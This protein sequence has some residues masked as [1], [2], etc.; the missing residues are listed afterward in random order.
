MVNYEKKLDYKDLLFAST[1]HIMGAGIFFLIQY[2]YESSKEKTWMSIVLSGLFMLIFSTAYSK[3]PKI[4][5]ENDNIEQK[6]ITNKFNKNIANIIILLTVI[7]MIFG[8]YIVSKSFGE[9]FSNL[10]NVS[11][12]IS[13]LLII[14]LC[15]LLNM[16]KIDALANFNNL[17]VLIGTGFTII[18]ILIG[19]YQIII[20]KNNIDFKSYYT[21]TDFND[22]KKNIWNIIKGAYLIIFAYFGFEII[23]KLNKESINPKKDI[24]NAINHS[25]YF[26]I[27]IYGLMGFIYAYSMSL[28][29][30]YNKKLENKIPITNSMELLT[31]TDKYNKL[32]NIIAITL[33]SDT[34]LTSMLGA[35]R[36]LDNVINID[37]KNNVPRKSII[38]ITLGLLILYHFNFSIEKSTYISNSFVLL[39]MISVI[40]S[41]KK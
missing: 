17:L 13:T 40:Y 14:G 25:M 22:F 36:L 20:D 18:I 38:I 26:V 24:P 32:V 12:E 11:T 37:A 3:L 29:K 30:K 21:F 15:F 6:I 33:T 41:M 1:G 4:S 27:I 31:K 5:N 35:S 8:G 28:K 2:V 19:L 9:Y 39:L 7:G 16:Y 23:I 10:F 34:V